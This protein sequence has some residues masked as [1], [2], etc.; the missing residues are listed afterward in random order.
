MAP[1]VATCRFQLAGLVG[2]RSLLWWKPVRISRSLPS[3]ARAR[4]LIGALRSREIG[5]LRTAA[6]E[7]ARALSR[8][9][10]GARRLEIDA[11][12]LLRQQVFARPQDIEVDRLVQVV[13]HRHVDH[14]DV[15]AVEEHLVILSDELHA[16]HLAKPLPLLL[17]HVADGDQLGRE[18]GS[19]RGQTSG[20]T[21]WPL[22]GPSGR[23][24]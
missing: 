18:P 6:H 1:H 13:G 7:A 22:R 11:E 5:E 12:R 21:R 15:V 19:G 4:Q 20:S 9:A 3:P 24:Q 10:H 2:S 17:G 8:L 14:V 23:H 16:G